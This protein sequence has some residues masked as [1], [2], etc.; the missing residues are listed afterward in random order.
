MNRPPCGVHYHH[1]PNR[2]P[3]RQTTAAEIPLIEMQ[4]CRAIF[5]ILYLLI[6]KS[7]NA[8]EAVQWKSLGRSVV[9]LSTK[10]A[11]V[12]GSSNNPPK[13]KIV[14]ADVD[15]IFQAFQ[16]VNPEANLDWSFRQMLARDCIDDMDPMAESHYLLSV[17]EWTERINKGIL[18]TDTLLQD[19]FIEPFGSVIIESKSERQARFNRF[20]ITKLGREE[21]YSKSKNRAADTR[22][23]FM[24]YH[25]VSIK[26][27][28]T[29]T[30]ANPRTLELT[31]EDVKA[32]WKFLEGERKGTH[33]SNVVQGV[34]QQYQENTRIDRPLEGEASLEK[35][36]LALK[37]PQ[38]PPRHP[39]PPKIGNIHIDTSADPITYPD[40]S[41][42]TEI[43]AVT[44]T[45]ENYVVCVV[46]DDVEHADEETGTGID[47][48][49][50]VTARAEEDRKNTIPSFPK[51]RSGIRYLKGR[52]AYSNFP[53]NS[54]RNETAS[55]EDG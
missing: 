4:H 37:F 6:S 35:E 17:Q 19:K 50:T 31:K 54:Q 45:A 38:I 26:C 49:A 20:P 34:S 30:R 47:L 11:Q 33:L 8:F 53:N 42:I 5:L 40:I 7:T 14:H 9:G 52:L 1:T 12:A 46:F 24:T 15:D 21:R 36:F 32:L 55:F 29:P 16:K 18:T 23:Q 41:L 22:A 39:K 10:V 44:G 48:T 51:Q 27:L 2:H 25:R 28:L 43:I 13:Q 3:T